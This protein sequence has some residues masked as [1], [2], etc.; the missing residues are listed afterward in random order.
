MIS[1]VG[2]KE[3]ET[4][5][6]HLLLD[7]VSV[8]SVSPDT[9]SSRTENDEPKGGVCEEDWEVQEEELEKVRL[10]LKSREPIDISIKPK[11]KPRRFCK[12][13]QRPRKKT[14]PRTETDEPKGE[15]KPVQE[16]PQLEGKSEYLCYVGAEDCIGIEQQWKQGFQMVRPILDPQP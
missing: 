4:N 2:P 6:S 14:T 13:H 5:I 15:A 7:E 11:N 1:L 10:L 16:P 8:E 3:P 12:S 9:P